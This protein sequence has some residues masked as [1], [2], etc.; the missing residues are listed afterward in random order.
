MQTEK[1]SQ[2]FL[3]NSF[4]IFPVKCILRT[5]SFQFLLLFWDLL[6]SS[7]KPLLSH[8]TGNNRAK[9]GWKKKEQDTYS[10]Y[11][12]HTS[13]KKEKKKCLWM[14]LNKFGSW[15]IFFSYNVTGSF[16]FCLYRIHTNAKLFYYYNNMLSKIKKYF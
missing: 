1:K 5:F 3:F 15:V 13:R 9:L 4:F 16:S 14:L 6:V 10:H 7:R 2:Y 12:N 8:L 11:I